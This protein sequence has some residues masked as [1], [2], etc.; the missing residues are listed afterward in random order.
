[1]EPSPEG[2]S[3]L[4]VSCMNFSPDGICLALARSDNCVHVYDSRML[5]RGVLHNYRHEN[6]DPLF[7]PPGTTLYGVSHTQWITTHTGQFALLSGGNDG[8]YIFP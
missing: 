4:E 8:G 7:N 2:A 5:G 3:D 6:Q 1:L